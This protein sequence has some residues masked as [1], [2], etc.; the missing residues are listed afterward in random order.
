MARGRPR[1]FDKDKALETAMQLFW[2]H[3]YEGTSVSM[4]CDAIGINVPSLYSAFGNKETLFQHTLE[5]YIAQ[6]ANYIH[7]ALAAPTAREVAEQLLHGAINMVDDPHNPD[8]CMIVHG[9]LVA[10]PMSDSVRNE[11]V[12]KRKMAESAI[13]KRFEDAKTSGDL[14]QSADAEK[15]ARFIITINWGNAV[16]SASGSSPAQ[17]ETVANIALQCW[18]NIVTATSS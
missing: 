5:L 10:T 17:L 14:P 16:Q 3:G 11:L 15:L 1:A 9:A 13:C 8:G 12:N 4:L 6:H 18:D 2:R 7:R